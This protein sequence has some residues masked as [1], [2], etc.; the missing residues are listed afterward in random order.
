LHPTKC[1]D[2][3]SGFYSYYI[4]KEVS[5]EGVSATKL[6]EPPHYR[7]FPI[8]PFPLQESQE[9]PIILAFHQIHRAVAVLPA[10]A[11]NTAEFT[12]SFLVVPTRFIMTISS[13]QRDPIN[14][15]FFSQLQ[16]CETHPDKK[17]GHTAP[18]ITRKL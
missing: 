10:F 13:S 2:F 4:I 14:A 12:S 5:A 8:Q 18:I 17:A 3:K 15:I 7:S 1:S 11:K 9:E 6:L 16:L